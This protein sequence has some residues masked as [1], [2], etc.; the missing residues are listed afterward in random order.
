MKNLRPFDPARALRVLHKHRVRFVLIGGFAARLWGS[1]TITNDID[2]CYARDRENLARLAAALKELKARLRAVPA[3]VPF[4]LDAQTLEAGDH[5]TFE[6]RA[7]N[8]DIF[9]LPA[10]S[11]GYDGLRRTAEEMTVEGI[12]VEVAAVED[13]IAM[14]R[15]AGRAKDLVEVEIL[16]ALREEIDR[17]GWRPR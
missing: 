5:F 14:K 9:G 1:P 6:T 7:G 15:A 2:L 3:V 8:L 12:R 13:L 10:G 16:S 4:L 17:G 11:G